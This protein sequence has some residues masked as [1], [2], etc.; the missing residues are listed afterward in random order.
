MFD[1]IQVYTIAIRLKEFLI[2]KGRKSR[3]LN[4]PE[5]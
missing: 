2:K 3:C 1:I 5:I 4:E